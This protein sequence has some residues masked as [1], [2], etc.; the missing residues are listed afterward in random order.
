MRAF[1]LAAAALAIGLT[2]VLTPV[3]QVASQSIREVFVV[4]FPDPQRVEGEVSLKD[5]VPMSRFVAFREVTVPPVRPEDTT[6][7]IDAGALDTD[8][9]PAVVLSLHG[10]VKGEVVK[11]GE[12]GTLVVPDEEAIR[13]A[14]DERGVVHFA[15]RAAAGNVSSATPFFASDQPRY[16]VGFSRYRVLLYNTTDK[17]VTANVFVYLTQ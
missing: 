14:F 1:G 5:P 9:F 13:R 11:A 2:L 7:L 15:L 6:R 3:G 8:G 17:A 10:E 4:N 12:V 16:R